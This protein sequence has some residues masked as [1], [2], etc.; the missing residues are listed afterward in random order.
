MNIIKFAVLVIFIGMAS[1]AFSQEITEAQIMAKTRELSNIYDDAQLQKALSTLEKSKS[2]AD[3]VYAYKYYLSQKDE[4]SIERV[5][6]NGL[7]KFPK[8]IFSNYVEMTRIAALKNL[9][10]KNEAYQKLLQVNPSLDLGM[11]GLSMTLGFAA[12][13]DTAL[14]NTYL[15][16]YMRNAKTPSGNTISKVSMY[17]M[18]INN[19]MRTNTKLAMPYL[20]YCLAYY[21]DRLQNQP[22]RED[23]GRYYQVIGQYSDILIRDNK[24]E[25]A[26]QYLKTV[27]YEFLSSKREFPAFL[28]SRLLNTHLLTER[29]ADIFQ[30]LEKAYV[31]DEKLPKLESHLKKAYTAKNKDLALYDKYIDSLNTEKHNA[32]VASILNSAINKPAPDFELKDVDGNL[33]K[34]S[35][36]KGKVLVLDF[37]AT[38]CGPCKASFPMMQKAVNKFKED[39]EVKFLFIHTWDTAKDPVKDAKDYVVTNGYTFEVLMD[40]K[41]KTT[42]Q[43]EVATKFNVKGI[44]AKFII[45]Q[46]GNIRFQASGFSGD[47]EKAIDE[48]SRMID[49]AKKNI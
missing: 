25:E 19:L 15:D 48:L 4:E 27:Q 30:S 9:N 16:Y 8:G 41:N 29:Y 40:L 14:M 32:F 3:L 17:S 24:S 37:W 2:Q 21:R 31:N 42:N 43:S 11:E 35:D 45:D 20:D 38:W 12:Q 7:N 46:K 39:K 33:V 1:P 10:E 49:F 13:G 18:L 26:F 6:K 34:L 47:E 22:N 36:L 28:Q 44:P 23:Q 5:K